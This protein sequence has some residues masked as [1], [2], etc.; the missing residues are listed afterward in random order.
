MYRCSR[1]G[2]EPAVIQAS[3]R[4]GRCLNLLDITA[5]NELAETHQTLVRAIGT[6]RM[7]RNTERG[8]H[9]LDCMVID[10]YCRAV[11]EET[12]K[13]IQSVRGTFSEGETIYAGSKILRKSHTQ[14][15]VRDPACILR[16][17]LVEFS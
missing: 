16:V 12:T 5:M 15:A 2:G 14:I 3:I 7:P 6:D 4:L 10:S 11:E 8:A 17:S 9:Y 1:E 13:E